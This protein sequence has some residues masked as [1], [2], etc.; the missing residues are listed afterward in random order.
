MEM[1]FLGVQKIIVMSDV[2]IILTMFLVLSW[3]VITPFAIWFL[4]MGNAY[5]KKYIGTLTGV[6]VKEGES[7]STR[8][9]CSDYYYVQEVFKKGDS[10]ETCLVRRRQ[11]YNHKSYANHFAENTILGTTRTIW[12]E[13]NNPKLCYDRSIKS[14]NNDV[15]YTLI[16]VSGFLI[17]ILICSVCR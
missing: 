15:G 2:E 10:N 7:C 11:S 9:G 4:I 1:I 5:G 17:L 3:V 16:S 14:Y 13:Y 8:G 12:T 6:N